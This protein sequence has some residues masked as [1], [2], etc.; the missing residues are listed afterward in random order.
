MACAQYINQYMPHFITAGRKQN[1]RTHR[2]NNPGANDTHLEP[3]SASMIEAV[4]KSASKLRC[5]E[6]T[7]LVPLLEDTE[8]WS[9]DSAE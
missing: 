8:W 3:A 6:M 5:Y 9:A 4:L 7:Y 2:E 1:S